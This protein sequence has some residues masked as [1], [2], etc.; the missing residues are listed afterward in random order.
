MLSTVH[1]LAA[2]QQMVLLMMG[3]GSSLCFFVLQAVLQY[4]PGL[5][6][7]ADTPE[8]Q[9]RYAETVIYR[10]FY[11]VNRCAAPRVGYGG[12]GAAT[13]GIRQHTAVSL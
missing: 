1:G 10:I 5:E 3:V 4:H 12:C 9:A 13:P 2:W 11:T 6:F 8:F 7:L